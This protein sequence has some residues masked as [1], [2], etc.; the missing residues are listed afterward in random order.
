MIR[1]LRAADRRV[2]LLATCTPHNLAAELTDLLRTFPREPRF[3]YRP[4]DHEELRAALRA[5][6][7]TGLHAE[8]AREL[9]LEARMCAV[10]GTP[11]LGRLARERYVSSP[12][13]DALAARWRDATPADVPLAHRSDDDADPQSLI[14][15]LRQEVGRH[16]LPMRVRSAE[17][18]AL[19]ATGRNVIFVQRGTMMTRH[20]VERT[21]LH[22]IEGHALPQTRAS[23]FFDAGT[24]RGS[25]GQEGRAIALEQ[26]AGMLD[27]GRKRELARRH[28]AALAMRSGADFVETV[29]T[30]DAELPDA[31]RIAA[32]VHRGGGLGRELAYLTHFLYFQAASPEVQAIMGRGRVCAR[33][34]SK[35]VGMSGHGR[36]YHD[37]MVTNPGHGYVV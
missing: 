21:V 28:L 37:E 17:I 33:A 24:A 20:D 12:E 8:R 26:E 9:D 27:G 2:R 13:A 6:P 25:D 31:L 36:T 18:A 35:L 22:E 16:K 5:V 30:L 7:W 15:R 14:R 34:A 4:V 19:A 1:L 11:E 23:G 29:R 10:A 32:R 3:S